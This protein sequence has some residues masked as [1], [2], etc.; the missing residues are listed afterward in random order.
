MIE[1][2]PDF[3]I[4]EIKRVAVEIDET[5]GDGLLDQVLDP[6]VGHRGDDLI[7][8]AG[9]H[10]R[11]DKV[12]DPRLRIAHHGVRKSPKQVAPRDH[13][14]DIRLHAAIIL[15]ARGLGGLEQQARNEIELH[16][17]PRATVHHEAGQES[18][19]GKEVVRLL[20]VAVNEHVLPRHQHLIHD[21]DRVI[22]IESAR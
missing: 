7:S 22:L 4:L 12:A 20:E 19:A 9:I 21:E 8:V 11:Q 17:Q 1:I 6:R 15:G 10:V 3:R 2:G 16:R 13:L 14:A 18:G 5:R